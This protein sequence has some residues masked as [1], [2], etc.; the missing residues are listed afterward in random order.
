MFVGE[1]SESLSSLDFAGEGDRDLTVEVING[2]ADITIE[3]AK[4][5]D[6]AISSKIQ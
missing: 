2:P 1:G 5:L 4:L 3:V 6:K